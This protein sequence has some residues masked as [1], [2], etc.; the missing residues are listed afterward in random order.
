MGILRF[1]TTKSSSARPLAAKSSRI[2]STRILVLLPLV[3]CFGKGKNTCVVEAFT[4]IIAPL[5]TTKGDVTK[6][7]HAAY[8]PKTNGPLLFA[9]I[10]AEGDMGTMNDFKPTTMT[11]TRSMIFF[12]RYLETFSLESAIKKRLS[13]ENKRG[14]LSKFGFSKRVDHTKYSKQ[15][16]NKLREEVQAEQAEKKSLRETISSLNKSR[17]ELIDLVGYDASLLVPCFGFAMLA[18]FMNSVIPHYYGACV[19]CIANA[20]TTTRG[21]VLAA[22]TGLGI[23]SALCSIFTG[24]RGA[25][26]WLAGKI[27]FTVRIKLRHLSYP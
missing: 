17:K 21:E 24:S 9:S 15:L 11:L 16:L 8:I 22:L 1:S 18:A 20:A 10:N 6:K 3:A 14:I 2:S 25:L 5:P 19:T 12:A 7:Y 4:N 27:T 23:S 13:Q 26:F